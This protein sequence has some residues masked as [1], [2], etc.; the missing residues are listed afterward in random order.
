MKRP[1]PN[2]NRPILVATESVNGISIRIL[3]PRRHSEFLSKGINE[4][5]WM[6]GYPYT[7]EE[8]KERNKKYG[9]KTHF[10][11]NL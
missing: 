2:K 5:T 9:W 10:L 11:G 7:F 8:F 6:I 1:K 4:A 3:Y